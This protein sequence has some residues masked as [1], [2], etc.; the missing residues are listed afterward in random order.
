MIP[1][2][3]NKASFVHRIF[4]KKS[5]SRRDWRKIQKNQRDEGNGPLLTKSWHERKWYR[6][7]PSRF[8]ICQTFVC[9]TSTCL[10]IR[11]ILVVGS[12]LAACNSASKFT[13]SNKVDNSRNIVYVLLEKFCNREFGCHLYVFQS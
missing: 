7:R 1:L 11:S 2:L 9:D 5:A 10:L 12:F 13:L 6:C 3:V 8:K 4:L